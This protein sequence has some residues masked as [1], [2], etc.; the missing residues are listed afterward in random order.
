VNY[1]P[2]IIGTLALMLL[3]TFFY[4]KL[5][6]RLKELELEGDSD[7]ALK[8]FITAFRVILFAVAVLC[9]ILLASIAIESYNNCETLLV[10]ETSI[11]IVNGTLTTYSYDS[12]CVPSSSNAASSLYDMT[13]WLTTLIIGLGFIAALYSVFIWVANWLRDRFMGGKNHG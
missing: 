12:V 3:S 5:G 13:L 11:D 6:N 8:A 1:L 7:K 9:M 4:F 10:N 2:V